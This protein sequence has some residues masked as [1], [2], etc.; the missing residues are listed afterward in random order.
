VLVDDS[1][2]RYYLY[3]RIP[4]EQVTDPFS[5]TY[6]GQQGIDAYRLAIA[7]RYYDAIILDGGIGPLGKRI[8]H[9]L[10][11]EIAQYYQRVYNAEAPNRAKVEIYRQREPGAS[12]SD[13]AD[14]SQ[15]FDFDNGTQGWG[16]RPDRG[17]LRPGLQVDIQ[18]E[19]AWNGNASLAFTPTA[20]VTMLG[21]K[22]TGPVSRV[23]AQIYVV[24]DERAG[25]EVRIG[26]M[27]FDQAWQWHD[28]KFA[29]VLPVGRW[30]EITWT[31]SEPGVYNQ[32]GFKFQP[33]AVKT[34]YLAQVEVTP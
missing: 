26:M 13:P 17:E 2:V 27:G 5:V 29:N 3:P 10:G 6:R 34:A 21:V 1:A 11:G 31:L 28:D 22:R 7:D 32:I 16:G 24:P 30:T 18:R 14:G 23:R 19:P 20:D 15:V 12:A 8:R 4:T 9:E 25:V 33:G